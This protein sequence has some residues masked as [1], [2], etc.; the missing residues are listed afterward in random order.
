MTKDD[1]PDGFE[2]YSCTLQ[3]PDGLW[4]EVEKTEDGQ[5]C[6][7]A[8]DHY[9]YGD[10]FQSALWWVEEYLGLHKAP[11]IAPAPISEL[12]P[13]SEACD[14]PPPPP[15]GDLIYRR[16]LRVDRPQG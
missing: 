16:L 1:I 15:R 3:T 14:P 11:E 2:I 8:E 13:S 5:W 12:G 4:I 10:T 6:V 7:S 9:G